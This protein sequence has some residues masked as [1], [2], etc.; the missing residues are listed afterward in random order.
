MGFLSFSNKIKIRL[1]QE[2]MAFTVGAVFIM[3][4]AIYTSQSYGMKFA[5]L[6]LILFS[7]IGIV[8]SL[9]SGH[10]SDRIGRKKM[11]AIAEILRTTTI[12]VLIVANSPSI[13]LPALSVALFLLLRVSGGLYRPASEAMIIDI[14]KSGEE[15]KKV[16][17][18][19]YW[20]RNVSIAVGA[21]IGGLTYQHH[22][23]SLFIGLGILSVISNIFVFFF[24]TESLQKKPEVKKANVFAG[25]FKGY[26]DVLKDKLFIVFSLAFMFLGTVEIQFQNYISVRMSKMP[27][28]YL[29]SHSFSGIEI[30]GYITT[31]NTVLVVGLTL[32]IGSLVAKLIGGRAFL[33]A[34]FINI[35]GFAVLSYANNAWILFIFMAVAVIGEII[36]VPTLQYFMSNLPKKDK[37][38][39][40]MAFNDLP[41][42]AANIIGSLYITLGGFLNNLAMSIVIFL[43]GMVGWMMFL[44]IM[45]K[46]KARST[47]A[48]S[49]EKE[50]EKAEAEGL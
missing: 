14:S 6:F 32:I 12:I 23:F 13:T 11:M 43:T 4:V 42:Y 29:F 15:R 10:Y 16:Y 9:I 49:A 36:Y 50:L 44:I 28:Q 30:Y 24:M 5:G 8:S 26:Q 22:L 37:I 47:A 41:I 34:I 38:S 31:E 21:M 27:S 39:S 2:F 33:I 48:E 45:P 40:Y 18:T 7:V 19:I 20:I 17:T 1:V 25:M 35:L 3:F 46:L